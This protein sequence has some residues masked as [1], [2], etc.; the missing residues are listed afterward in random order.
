MFKEKAV[1]RW[2]YPT[3]TRWVYLL[4][5]GFPGYFQRKEQ[6]KEGEKRKF[7]RGSAKKKHGRE[8][9]QPMKQKQMKKKAQKKKW[10]GTL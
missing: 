9:K 5:L 1:M 7:R 3:G 4:R 2:F 8:S 10:E 6:Q